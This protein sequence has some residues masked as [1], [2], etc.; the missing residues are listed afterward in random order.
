M[1]ESRCPKCQSSKFDRH[2]CCKHCGEI[3]PETL[4]F[5]DEIREQLANKVKSKGDGR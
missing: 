4:K 2:G 3:H 5:M 1:S